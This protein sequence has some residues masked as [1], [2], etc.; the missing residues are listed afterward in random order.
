MQKPDDGR[1][2]PASSALLRQARAARGAAARLAG[3]ARAQSLRRVGL[4]QAVDQV[5]A[6]VRQRA[7]A[8]RPLDA[9]VQDVVEDVL[10]G[11]GVGTA[12]QQLQTPC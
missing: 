7:L 11:V 3:A 10:R 5:A 4:Q 9:P 8:A 12:S 1:E 6:G 2:A